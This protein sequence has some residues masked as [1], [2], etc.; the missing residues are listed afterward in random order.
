M[1]CSENVC[2]YLFAST[3]HLV[4]IFVSECITTQI[5]IY[6]DDNTLRLFLVMIDNFELF[7]GA[8]ALLIGYSIR[9]LLVMFE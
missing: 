8:Y 1:I 3:K 5:P 7:F 4:H 6:T 9:L 2:T